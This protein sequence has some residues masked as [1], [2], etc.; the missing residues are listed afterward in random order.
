MEGL[1][2][3]LLCMFEIVHHFFKKPNCCRD[4]RL[5]GA[6]E[7][8]GCRNAV[9]AAGMGVWA[10]SRAALGGGAHSS[11]PEAP[12][13]CGFCWYCLRG[14]GKGGQLRRRVRGTC[15]PWRGWFSSVI[16]RLETHGNCGP[17]SLPCGP[18][19]LQG[20]WK[21]GSCLRLRDTGRGRS[22]RPLA[23]TRGG[24]PALQPALCL[25]TGPPPYLT[26]ASWTSPIPPPPPASSDRVREGRFMAAAVGG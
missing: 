4:R 17:V 20:C 2:L 18:R 16:C 26:A 11:S 9:T 22:Q 5:A 21:S 1:L 24:S 14:A 13:G 15:S 23:R 6:V 25:V 8:V 12:Q 19:Q 7:R 3:V 10:G